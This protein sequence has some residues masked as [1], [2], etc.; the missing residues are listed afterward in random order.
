MVETVVSNASKQSEHSLKVNFKSA[1]TDGT[2]DVEGDHPLSVMI[3]EVLVSNADPDDCPLKWIPVPS[4][5]HSDYMNMRDSALIGHA[6]DV[7]RPVRKGDL[8]EFIAKDFD[9]IF[10]SDFNATPATS[11]STPDIPL[12][13]KTCGDWKTS[14]NTRPEKPSDG[15]SSKTFQYDLHLDR[16]KP[17]SSDQS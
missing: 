3:L 14:S 15:N 9:K 2:T 5:E 6:I 12:S 17:P 11:A 7:Q 10:G 8:E 16:D 13:S 4:C 1:V